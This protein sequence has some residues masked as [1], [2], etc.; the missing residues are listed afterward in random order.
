MAMIQ[1]RN[2]MIGVL[3]RNGWVRMDNWGGQVSYRH[4]DP[5]NWGHAIS[6]IN[7]NLEWRHHDNSKV[8][9]IGGGHLLAIGQGPVSLEQHLTL[10][11]VQA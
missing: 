5:K 7:A 11:G 10:K 2:K 3:K 6:I 8:G 1:D 9:P 4:T